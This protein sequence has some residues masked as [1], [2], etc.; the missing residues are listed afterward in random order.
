[1]VWLG[2]FGVDTRSPPDMRSLINTGFFNTW[3]LFVQD[4]IIVGVRFHAIDHVDKK[5]TPNIVPCAFR[6]QDLVIARVQYHAIDQVLAIDLYLAIKLYLSF[7]LTKYSA[8]F[9]E[10]KGY[11]GITNNQLGCCIK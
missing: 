10:V 1:M 9:A 11:F 3:S 6:S 4:L 7:S 8:I 5:R 2:Q